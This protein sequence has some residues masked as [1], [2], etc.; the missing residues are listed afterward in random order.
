MPG[1]WESQ[2]WDG[3][4]KRG[5]EGMEIAIQTKE[6]L[7]PTGPGST[8]RNESLISLEHLY[9][10]SKTVTYHTKGVIFNVNLNLHGHSY[11]LVSCYSG[12]CLCIGLNC[13]DVQVV[14]S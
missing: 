10:V 8:L 14:K 12:M 1:S 5:L 9:R 11:F 13:L 2:P 6:L 7:V 3:K 4:G